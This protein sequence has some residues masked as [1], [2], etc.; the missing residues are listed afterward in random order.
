[1]VPFVHPELTA[2]HGNKGGLNSN[3]VRTDRQ[4]ADLTGRTQRGPKTHPKSLRSRL[5]LT[6]YSLTN[7]IKPL[8][9]V[10]SSIKTFTFAANSF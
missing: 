6:D 10:S 2:S 9:G 5:D 4:A 1:M 7:S 3:K 8:S